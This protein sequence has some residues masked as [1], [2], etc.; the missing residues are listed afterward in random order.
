MNRE[1]K[2]LLKRQGQL[3]EDGSYLA[4]KAPPT[5]SAGRIQARD[6]A[7]KTNLV[8]RVVTFFKEVVAELKKVFWPTRE[9]VIN[10]SIL[11]FVALVFVGLLVFGIDFGC[12]KAVVFLF[13]K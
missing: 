8:S 11:V 2:R 10:Y 6:V 5:P 4:P 3:A 13:K 7:Q 9:E 12:T 1:T